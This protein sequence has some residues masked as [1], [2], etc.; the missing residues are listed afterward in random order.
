MKYRE[1]LNRL[2]LKLANNLGLVYNETTKKWDGNNITISNWN[3]T[4]LPIKFGNIKGDFY[5]SNNR[6]T[7]LVGGPS[8][9]GGSFYCYNNRLTSLVGG[10]SEVGGGF[11]CHNNSLTSLEGGPS[12][13][14]GGFSCSYNLIK[15]ER[16]EGLVCR[17]FYN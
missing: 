4:R 16:P 11:Y 8:K 5:C 3:L 9:V 7:S 6:L 2:E 10:P 15:L 12:K 1:R 17:M 13:V 14:G